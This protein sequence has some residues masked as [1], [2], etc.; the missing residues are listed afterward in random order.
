MGWNS[1]MPAEYSETVLPAS[2]SLGIYIFRVVH[3]NVTV[4]KRYE[5]EG[6]VR[7]TAHKSRFAFPLR[8]FLHL[9]AGN[10]GT[11]PHSELGRATFDASAI[12]YRSIGLFLIKR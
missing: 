9:F 10:I 1:A 4:L 5:N 12:N 7:Y 2:R 3:A 8:I 6:D 11:V